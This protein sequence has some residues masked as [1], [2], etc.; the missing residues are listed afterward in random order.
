MPLRQSFTVRSASWRD[1][2]QSLQSLRRDVFIIEQRVP[3]EL[4][5]D[6]ADA[7]S[8]HALALDAE[9]RPIGTGRLLP[10]GHI[11][12][13]AVLHGWRGRGVGSAIMAWLM[14][15]ARQR[16]MRELHLHAQIHAQG[17]YEKFGF[18]AHGQ[19][20][21]EAGISHRKMS[22]SL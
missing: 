9:G 22:L 12:R 18:A 17:F 5:W 8:A 20:F 19:A 4:E 13:M 3:E 10:D 7:V 16:G 6:D 1:D 2:L 11:G 14:N 15:E 21:A